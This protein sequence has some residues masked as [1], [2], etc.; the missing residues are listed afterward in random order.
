MEEV[1]AV[2]R[3]G[4]SCA[5]DRVR[6]IFEEIKDIGQEVVEVVAQVQVP[7]IQ[8]TAGV[9]K[10]IPQERVFRTHSGADRG[11]TTDPGTWCWSCQGDTAAG[12]GN[13]WEKRS[14]R[15]STSFFQCERKACKLCAEV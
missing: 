15:W 9:F 11:G 7:Q 10:V 14:W 2:A 1:V 8:E 13:A 5:T 3:L 4:P 12:V 6:E